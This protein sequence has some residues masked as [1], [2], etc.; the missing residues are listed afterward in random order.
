MRE[1]AADRDFF[2]SERHQSSLSYSTIGFAAIA[3]LAMPRLSV[4]ATR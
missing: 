2:G 4:V 3:S 1:D